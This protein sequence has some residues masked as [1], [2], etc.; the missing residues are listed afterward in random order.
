MH[1]IS[2]QLMGKKEGVYTT[3]SIPFPNIAA[4]N[5]E[6]MLVEEFDERRVGQSMAVSP[7][8]KEDMKVER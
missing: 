6:S 7:L 5:D 8:A 2:E 3:P 4:P 1:C